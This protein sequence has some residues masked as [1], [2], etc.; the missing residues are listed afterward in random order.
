MTPR[1]G[2]RAVRLRMRV[3]R[4]RDL[5]VTAPAGVFRHF[6]IARR[7]PDRIGEGAGRE[8]EGVPEA[9]ARLGLVFPEQVVRRVTVVAHRHCMVRGL[10]PRVEVLAHHVAVGARLG[11]VGQVGR[12]AGVYERERADA[13][14]NSDNN[15]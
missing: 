3:D 5:L 6:V 13:N 12:T 2:D 14:G 1:A 15:C 10:D 7:D 4:L 8:V 11:V 9:V